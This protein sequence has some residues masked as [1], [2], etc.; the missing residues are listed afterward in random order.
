[1]GSYDDLRKN[2]RIDVNI[3]AAAR[4]RGWVRRKNTLVGRTVNLALSGIQ[5]QLKGN[6]KV[7]AGDG[8]EIRVS[9]PGSGKP[10]FLE[11]RIIWSVPSG[12]S[13]GTVKVGVQLTDLAM[14]DYDTWVKFLYRYLKD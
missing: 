12:G 4:V 9:D 2:R 6:S 11:G 8:V 7:K 3:P 1:M 13:D 10:L 14:K 5:L